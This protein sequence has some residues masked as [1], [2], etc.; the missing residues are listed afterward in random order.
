[1]RAILE[2][3]KTEGTEEKHFSVPSV[4]SCSYSANYMATLARWSTSAPHFGRPP[5]NACPPLFLLGS[6][7]LAGQSLGPIE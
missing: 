4:F 5:P 6:I 1:V 2:Q 7:T 3:E